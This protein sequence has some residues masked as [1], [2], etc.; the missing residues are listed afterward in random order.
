MQDVTVTRP[1]SAQHHPSLGEKL[2][3]DR[4]D[5]LLVLD[6]QRDSIAIAF[7]VRRRVRRAI[8]WI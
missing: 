8:G 1:T 4:G 5:A 2:G 3:L 6:L 7:Q